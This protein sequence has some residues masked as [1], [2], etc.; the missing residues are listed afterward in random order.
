MTAVCHSRPRYAYAVSCSELAEL[1]PHFNFRSSNAPRPLSTISH[2][3]TSQPDRNAAFGSRKYRRP[4][5]Y[6][7]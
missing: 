1:V 7:F 5:A 3:V 2:K 6:T 4:N